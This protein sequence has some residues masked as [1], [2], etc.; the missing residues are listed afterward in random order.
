[1]NMYIKWPFILLLLICFIPGVTSVATIH[2]FIPK[3]GAIDTTARFVIKLAPNS[4]NNVKP[5]QVIQSVNAFTANS[6]V[7]KVD[8]FSGSNVYGITAK[9]L[10]GDGKVDLAVVNGGGSN[11]SVFKNNSTPGV[12]SFDAPLKYAVN[13]YS[14]G[15][16][17]ED[18]DGDGKPD[19][20]VTNFNANTVTIFKNISVVNQLSFQLQTVLNTGQGAYGVAISDLDADGK[21]DIVV[22]NE[23]DYP[24]TISVLKNTSSPGLFSFAAKNDFTVTS[25]PRGLSIGDLDADGKPDVVVACQDGNV[26]VLKNS[27][28]AGN[29][30]FNASIAY[31]LA[32]GFGTESTVIADVDGDGK[33]DIA[34]ANNNVNGTISVLKNIGTA[35]AISFGARK[36]FSAGTNPFSIAA[37]DIDGDGKP[38]LVVANQLSNNASVF[39]NSGSAGNINFNTAV[40]FLAGTQPRSLVVADIDGNHRADLVVGNN[41][42]NTVSVLLAQNVADKLP[43]VITLPLQLPLLDANNNYDPKASSTNQETPI[44]YTSS[45]PAVATIAS[46]GLVHVIAP[47]VTYITAHQAG[48]ANYDDAAPVTQT[49]T[50]VE[51]LYLYMPPIAGK[52]ICQADFPAD[53]VSSNS[54]IPITYTSNNPAV[55]TVS[56]QGVIHIT[57]AGSVTIK[58]MQNANPPLYVSATPVSQT[59]AV[60]VPPY[61]VVNITANYAGKCAG[62]AVTFT[63]TTTNT[64]ANP[65][66]QWQLNGVNTGT[67]NSVF[68]SGTLSNNDIVACTVTNNNE[69]P[70]IAKATSNHII[71]SLISPSTPTVSITASTNGVFAGTPITFNAATTGTSGTITYQ[72][73]VNNINT[74]LNSNVFTANTF[75]N[76]DQVTCAIT[77][78]AVCSAPAISE[79]LIVNIVTRLTIPNSFTPNGDGV[80]DT[81]FISG[82]ASYPNSFLTVF[83]RYGSP[84]YQAKNYNNAWRGVFNGRPL[85]SATYYYVIDLGFKN[86]KLSGWVTILR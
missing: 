1:M 66:Y 50:V 53:V 86:T 57:G 59:F 43:S 75:A 29:I 31:P 37:A 51:T 83:N 7:N 58:A 5:R 13:D 11:I 70:D 76:A 60:S 78:D 36:D 63:A 6:F 2:S 10:D 79:P 20:V 62:S 8:I 54:V 24:G 45:N 3:S 34:A 52:T 47:G 74:G 67:N 69:C 16:M 18:L 82:I 48:N 44:T 39:I 85:P 84:V 9:D 19:L 41:G 22:T 12:V 61:P 42:A 27:S 25:F 72:W 21:P 32:A 49:L 71:V 26:C 81:W 14:I 28:T 4:I 65:T 68:A 15:I 55:A 17:A 80:N 46:N 30:S 35:G 64:G 40:D 38:D 33:P 73:Q 77:T 23:K 56:S